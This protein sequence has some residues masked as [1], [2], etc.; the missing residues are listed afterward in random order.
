MD[1]GVG[2]ALKVGSIAHIVLQSQVSKCHMSLH[3]RCQYLDVLIEE[4]E[5]RR[6]F[7]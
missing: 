4:L 5:A 3:K 2:H 1:F 7:Q 6:S